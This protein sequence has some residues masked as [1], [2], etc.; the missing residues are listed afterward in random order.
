VNGF[1][2]AALL[3][4][5]LAAGLGWGA[6]SMAQRHK[7]LS[8]TETVD[9]ATL[10]ELHRTA[11]QAAGPDAFRLVVDLEGTA[12]PGPG[13]PL[14][15][16]LTGADCVWHKHSVV[17]KD[18]VVELEDGKRVTRNREETESDHTTETPFV[19]RDATGEV[20]VVPSRAVDCAEQ[21]VDDFVRAGLERHGSFG[22]RGRTIGRK[23]CEWLLRPGTRVFVHGEAV[24]RAGELVVVEPKGTDKLLVT[25]RSEAEV[26]D[27]A[28]S[29]HKWMRIGAA[30]SAALAV[31]LGVVG[32]VA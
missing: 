1:L 20:V 15:A 12:Q 8:G 27:K 16:A 5:L 6:W 30:A 29:G 10:R 19:V 18:Q 24:D 13:G 22:N 2:I 31:V 4:L 23:R 11:T 7:H 14:K 28:A 25:T 9:L 17:R 32:V 26:L 3:L 21:T